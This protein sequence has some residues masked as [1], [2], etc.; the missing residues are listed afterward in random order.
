MTDN[1]QNTVTAA[2]I[3]DTNPF[4]DIDPRTRVR[5][6]LI[7]NDATKT[8]EIVNTETGEYGPVAGFF[9]RKEVD[10]ETFVKVYAK[11]LQEVHNLTPAGLK[12]FTILITEMRKRQATDSVAIN[13]A[14]ASKLTKLSHTTF[15]RGMEDLIAKRFIGRA[16]IT[17]VWWL[18][19]EYAFNGDRLHFLKEYRLKQADKKQRPAK[20]ITQAW[21]DPKQTDLEDFTK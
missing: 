6:R 2:P 7:K 14:A 4:L 18:N 15:L 16:P 11:G 12:V 20:P 9:D 21:T 1:H 19:P 8:F 10:A 3:H 13:Y 17:N 5:A